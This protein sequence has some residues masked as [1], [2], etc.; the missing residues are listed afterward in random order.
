MDS[1]DLQH[2]FIMLHIPLMGSYFFISDY[3]YLCVCVYMLTK[4]LVC[5]Y[6]VQLVRSQP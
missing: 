4:V 5:L 3:K 6:V 1:L 2:M